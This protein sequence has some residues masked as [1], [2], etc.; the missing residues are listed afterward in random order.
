MERPTKTP[1]PPPLARGDQ[2]NGNAR[3]IAAGEGGGP[4]QRKPRIRPDISDAA[5]FARPSGHAGWTLPGFHFSPGRLDALQVREAGLHLDQRPHRLDS[6]ILA[7][8]T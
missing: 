3:S 6:I 5:R 2:R 4:P 8:T 1:S 7:G